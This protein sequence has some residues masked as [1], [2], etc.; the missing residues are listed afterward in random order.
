MLKLYRAAALPLLCL[1]A[2]CESPTKPTFDDEDAGGGLDAGNGGAVGMDGSIADTGVMQPDAQGNSDAGDAGSDAGAPPWGLDSRLENPTCHAEALGE[3][4][5]TLL[6]ATGCVKADAP[7]EPIAALIPFTL[8]SPL[9]SDQA[10]KRRWVALPDGEAATLGPDGDIVF[11]IG[12]IMV[13]EFRLGNVRLETRFLVHYPV[14][15]DGGPQTGQ[16]RGFSYQWKADQSDAELVA[17][18][19]TTPFPVA[20]TNKDWLIPTRD[21]C[22]TCHNLSVTGTIGPEIGQLN[23]DFTY[24]NGRTAN[25][26]T[27]LSHIGVL[28]PL[29]DPAT[30]TKLADYTDVSA[31]L[32]SRARAYL[33]VNCSF[34]HRKNPEP[35]GISGPGGGPDEFRVTKSLAQMGICNATPTNGTAV[36]NLGM[37]PGTAKL[38]APSDHENSVLWQRMNAR[39]SEAP[40]NTAGQHQMPPIATRLRDNDGVELI[41]QW[42]ETIVTSCPP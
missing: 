5:P 27:T 14:D 9:W 26:L 36:T 35:G 24:P 10:E 13:K 37:D 42:I 17:E 8:N 32:D 6:S 23:R 28:P 3:D 19:A 33:H 21:E 22:G 18:G 41:Q 16:W 20:G 40:E 39:R 7:S 30:L 15:H 29:A 1:L 38:L 2:S 25:Q 4:P 12:T 34:C 11:P 31:D